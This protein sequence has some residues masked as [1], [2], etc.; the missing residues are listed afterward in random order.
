MRFAP[1]VRREPWS[2]DVPVLLATSF[3]K[4]CM[5]TA[6]AA[7]QQGAIDEDCLAINVWTK[8]GTFLVPDQRLPVL[9][10]I[11]GGEFV[12]GGANEYAFRGDILAASGDV[13]VVTFQYRLGIFG[14]GVLDDDAGP[15]L[16]NSGLL[17]QR[18]AL[19][20]VQVRAQFCSLF[21]LN[22]L[23]AEKRRGFRVLIFIL[24]PNCSSS[25]R[26]ARMCTTLVPPGQHC[27]VR[28]RPK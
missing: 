26:L 18:M 20:W 7:H 3:Q 8:T 14:W 22:V 21:V 19:Q 9:V 28:W 4:A 16:S 10:W 1:P 11:H 17:D 27:C 6:S 2:P 13:V 5:Q 12:R 25:R 23:T 24:V 15:G